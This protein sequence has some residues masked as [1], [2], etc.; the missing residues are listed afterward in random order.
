MFMYMH[1]KKKK[2]KKKLFEKKT[3]EKLNKII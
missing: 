2:K 1:N 3:N